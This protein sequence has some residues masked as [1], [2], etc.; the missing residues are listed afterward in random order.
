MTFWRQQHGPD[1]VGEN[2]FRLMPTDPWRSRPAKGRLESAAGG[3]ALLLRYDWEHPDDGPQD[4]ILLIGS[5]EEQRGVEA[6]WLDSWHQKPGPLLLTG[7][8]ADGAT[9]VLAGT[10]L[11][12]WGWEIHLDLDAGLRM[13]MRNV[14]PASAVKAEQAQALSA[15]PYDVMDMRLAP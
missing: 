11:Q 7:T 3:S 12:E 1:L 14:I 5:P 15:G 10:Y 6:M 2:A 13:T 9:C 4:G 8:A